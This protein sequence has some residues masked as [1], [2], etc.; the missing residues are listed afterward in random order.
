MKNPN[1][2]M[3]R[4]QLQDRLAQLACEDENFRQSLLDN[5]KQAIEEAFK[6]R[7]LND[8]QIKVVEDS[9]DE[10]FIVVPSQREEDEL[11][12]GSLDNVAG[13]LL[14]LTA[15]AGHRP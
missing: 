12:E 11:G 13:G 15:H 10:F 3:T 4:G 5:P 8:I 2:A 14:T 6:T 9:R 1:E 7:L